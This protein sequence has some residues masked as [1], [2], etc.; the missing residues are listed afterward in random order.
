MDRVMKLAS[1]KAA[2]IFSK[3]SCCMCHA[4]KTLFYDL[5]VNP[6]IHDLIEHLLYAYESSV[7]KVAEL[8]G[9]EKSFV[10]EVQRALSGLH[11]T[12]LLDQ[13]SL[14]KSG[15][16][17]I[18]SNE[19]AFRNQMLDAI[20]GVSKSNKNV[21]FINSCFAH[22][23]SERQDTLFAYDSPMIQDKHPQG[24]VGGGAGDGVGHIVVFSGARAGAPMASCD[25]PDGASDAVEGGADIVGDRVSCRDKLPD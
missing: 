4:I 22:C 1:Q 5:D 16:F 18:C 10:V 20:K 15:G 25:P 3:S 21:L 13:A 8:Y 23:Q 17:T 2:V 6:A 7:R 11:Y 14:V 12:A 24:V 9:S 19:A